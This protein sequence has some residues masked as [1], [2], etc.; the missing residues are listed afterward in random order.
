MYYY[1]LEVKNKLVSFSSHELSVWPS[2]IPYFNLVPGVFLFSNM[3]V[4]LQNRQLEGNQLHYPV[5]R[6]LS[7]E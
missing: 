3:A 1:I 6:D 2:R 7:G 5:D 4:K